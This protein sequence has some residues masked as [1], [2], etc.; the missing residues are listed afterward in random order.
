MEQA[1]R[2]TLNALPSQL[3]LL[4]QAGTLLF[5]NDAWRR[6][7]KENQGDL[8]LCVEGANYVSVCQSAGGEANEFLEKLQKL[9]KGELTSFDLEYSCHSPEHERWYRAKVTHFAAKSASDV[10]AMILHEDITLQK[11]A[12]LK[13]T[14]AE[15]DTRLVVGQARCLLWSGTVEEIGKEKL[16]WKVYS[17]DED[18]AQR[19]LPIDIDPEKDFVQS[20]YLTR[21]P[22]D[23]LRT[24]QFGDSK[25]R[26]GESYTLEFRCRLKDGS[27][28]W[29][30]DDVAVQ[31]TG[32]GIWSVIGVTTDITAQ[33]Q[34]DDDLQ[35]LMT[36]AHCLLWHA[37]IE[38]RG[39]GNGLS[40][41]LTVPNE[42]AAMVFLFLS[43]KPGQSY[44]DAW[45]DARFEEEWEQ[46]HQR[47][48]AAIR[49]GDGYSQEF[50]C[51]RTDGTVLWLKE[52]VQVETLAPGRWKAVGV[53]T[54]ITARKEKEIALEARERHLRLAL[55]GGDLGSWHMDAAAGRFLQVSDLT[56]RTF[57][58]SLL[59]TDFTWDY[60]IQ[61]ILPEDRGRVFT[62][63]THV[64]QSQERD[65][66]E[67]RITLPDGSVRWMGAHGQA[68]PHPGG[69]P[70]EI[71]G[72]TR[73]ITEHKRIEAEHAKALI[74]AEERADR[75]PLTNLLNHRA[76]H[77]RVEEETARARRENTTL[78]IVMLDIDNFKFFNDVYGH[79]VGD[80][81]LR[82]VAQRLQET[83]RIY[84]TLCRFGGDEFALILPSIGVTPLSEIEARLR[85]SL[86]FSFQPEGYQ[87]AIPITVSQ[88]L[89]LFPGNA[90]DWHDALRSADERLIRAKTG[91]SAESEANRTRAH[92]SNAVEG[93]SMLDA[94]VTA[95]DNKDRYTKRHSEDVMTYSLQIARTLG[96]E[97]A[98]QQMIATAALLHDVGKIGVPDAILRKPGALSDEEFETVKLHP[99]MG[100]AIV[101]A[102]AGLEG[103]L[104]A[105]RYHHERWDGKGYPSGLRHEETP[106]MARL[107][108]VADAFSA[109]TTDR[110][111][112][113]GMPPQRAL[114]ILE[115]GAGT[116]WDPEMVAAFLEFQRKEPTLPLN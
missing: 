1:Y 81:V 37:M 25:V 98:L 35:R 93:F 92:M 23:S 101:G 22:Q 16:R 116:Q 66:V 111:Y 51:R 41:Q 54:D 87:S 83:C 44:A 42:E 79:T 102:V 39:E 88:G 109:M 60:F 70:T 30:R 56:Q 50:R 33:K 18:A 57:L 96:T 53:C 8:G 3:C 77:K 52:D 58:D 89:A 19:F 67:F 114:K 100:A 94:L 86:K 21:H 12:Q 80:H 90:R 59:G 6:F 10:C 20:L 112:R 113:A 108:A 65:S 36:E 49:R 85:E 64:L 115:D 28:V 31:P 95:V 4:D 9:L 84:D 29:L 55:E 63:I 97:P 15:A 17:Q 68:V 11:V 61:A 82:M 32:D 13:R 43:P 71:I 5:I 48:D 27:L 2:A 38:D 74:D 103:T 104:D 75:D 14:Q 73:D 69:K 91:G 62:T 78:A 24:D 105:V 46:L 45:N 7:T 26:A 34:K 106:W 107:M 76:F 110:P 72:V 47:S 40:W 99:T